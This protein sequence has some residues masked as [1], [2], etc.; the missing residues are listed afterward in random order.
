MNI[1]I[2]NQND[3]DKLIKVRFDYFATEKM[4]LTNEKRDDWFAVATVLRKTL[5]S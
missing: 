2:A 1:R 5:K 3:V 4:E